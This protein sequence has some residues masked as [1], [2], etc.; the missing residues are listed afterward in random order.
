MYGRSLAILNIPPQL[1]LLHVQ[2]H[3]HTHRDSRARAQE[4]SSIYII[5]IIII[6]AIITSQHTDAIVLCNDDAACTKSY[7]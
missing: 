5:I 4:T 1:I 7:I 6:I 2:Q 3:T